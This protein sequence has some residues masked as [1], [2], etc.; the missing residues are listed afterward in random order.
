MKSKKLLILIASVA[1]AV[2][3]IVLLAG[4]FSISGTPK[5]VYHDFSGK[6]TAAPA[7]GG[8]AP[9]DIAEFI[10][11]KSAVF[12][13]KTKLLEQ[14]N[15]TFLDWHAYAVKKYFPNV[16]E[17][18][19]TKRI[20]LLKLDVSGKEVY[21]DCFG[22]VMNAPSSGRVVDATSAFKSTDAKKQQLG[23]PFKFA[24][25][26]NDAKLQYVIQ[27]LLATWQ[28]KVETED[29]A[30]LLGYDNVFNF[31]EDGTMLIT[32]RSGGTIRILSPAVN[33]TERLI[34]AYG[35]Y[36]NEY[37]NLQSDD[38]V[39]TVQENGTITTPDPD[40]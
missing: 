16:I 1:A 36:Y 6:E 28:C 29:L 13:S 37:A 9:D 7:E 24:V 2:V 21:I 32:P 25:E 15:T 30:A 8:I 18:H 4:L 17:V 12:L 19:L 31:D 11:G 3:V 40:R 22:Y 34:H 23:A 35:V 38:W 14:I 27:A 33:L 26:D 39:I 5:L 10:N 20:A